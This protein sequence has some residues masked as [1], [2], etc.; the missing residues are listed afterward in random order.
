MNINKK[1]DLEYI[2]AFQKITVTA[3]CKELRIDKPSVY[4]GTASADNIKKVR[5]EIE[6]RIKQLGEL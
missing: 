5:E 1:I 4:R 3:I 6:K 2:K